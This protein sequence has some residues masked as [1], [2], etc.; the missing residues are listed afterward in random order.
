[1]N[2]AVDFDPRS[3]T[4][5]VED[6]R[7]RV[8]LVTGSTSGIGK[9]TATALVRAG[10]QTILLGRRAKAL[11]ALYQELRAVG[12]EPSVA[13]LDFERAQG[14]AYNTLTEQIE[15]RY[16]RL[17]GILLN[18]GMLGDRSPIEHYDIGVWQK[19][20]HVNVNAQFILVRCLIPLLRCSENASI[21]FTT[22]SVGHKGRANWGAYA[23][24]KFAIE[25]L[26]QVMAE[27]LV[28]SPIRVNCINPGGTRTRMRAH[29]YPGEDPATLPT[30]EQILPTYL[31]LLGAASKGVNGA[32]FNCQG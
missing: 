32:R 21:L 14:D 6:F 3:Y 5:T 15:Q 17:D 26:A 7:D 18:A 23:V 28:N 30:P 11:D 19:V 22:S 27:E 13:V 20:M 2:T 1:L 16:G 12:P 4:A 31:F 25:G 24:S 29:A 8:I 9:A 10:A